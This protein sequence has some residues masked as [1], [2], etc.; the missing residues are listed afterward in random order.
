MPTDIPRRLPATGA[1]G[2]SRYADETV[3][4]ALAAH[5]AATGDELDRRSL[6]ALDAPG[7]PGYADNHTGDTEQPTPASP[8]P[9]A[10]LAGSGAIGSVSPIGIKEP[11][12]I[13]VMEPVLGVENGH[14]CGVKNGRIS[15]CRQESIYRAAERPWD[16][17]RRAPRARGSRRCG[18]A[19]RR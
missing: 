3:F 4:S 7:R 17:V 13:G 18:A 12:M 9:Q 8:T 1:G 14:P 11:G 10:R 2:R 15:W 16:A 5:T 6:D 19:D